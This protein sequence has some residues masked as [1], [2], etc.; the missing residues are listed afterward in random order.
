MRST[1]RCESFRDR[2][3]PVYGNGISGIEI[4]SDIAPVAPVVSSFRKQRYVIQKVVDGVP[5]DWQWY[6]LFGSLERRLLPRERAGRRLR[7]PPRVRLGR[8]RTSARPHRPGHPRGRS[9]ALSD[10]LAQV[11]DGAIACRPAIA[12]IDGHTVTVEDGTSAT[13]EAI[14]CATGTT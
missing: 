14:V 11:E 4:A 3:T 8:R 6:T 9:R 2:A 10:Y 13:F 1:T 7:D 12:A 5:S